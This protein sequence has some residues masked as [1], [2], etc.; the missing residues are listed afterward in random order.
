MKMPQKKEFDYWIE[1]EDF[2]KV[3]SIFMSLKGNK[4]ETDQL[5]A[6]LKMSQLKYLLENRYREAF[7]CFVDAPIHYK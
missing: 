5:F 2:S 3:Q 1:A 4:K 7:N 6:T